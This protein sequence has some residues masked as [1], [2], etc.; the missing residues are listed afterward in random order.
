MSLFDVAERF[1]ALQDDHD[2]TIG[3]IDYLEGEIDSL[4][5]DL[6]DCQNVDC[7]CDEDEEEDGE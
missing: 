7:D 5:S 3:T 2:D 6:L 4:R 1:N